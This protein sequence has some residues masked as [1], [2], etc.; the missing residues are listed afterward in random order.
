[1]EFILLRLNFDYLIKT[2]NMKTTVVKSF[3][4]IGVVPTPS[5]AA[6]SNGALSYLIGGI[7]ALLIMGYLVYTLLRPEKF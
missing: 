1:V 6:A 7:M 5:E 3:M 2:K 4:L